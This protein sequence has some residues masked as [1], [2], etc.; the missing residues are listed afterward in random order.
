[1]GVLIAS[2]IDLALDGLRA[3]AFGAI[4]PAAVFEIVDGD[5]LDVIALGNDSTPRF[6]DERVQAFF[7]ELFGGPAA[8][9][10][11][12]DD[13]R[14]VGIGCHSNLSYAFFCAGAGTQPW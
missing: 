7:G 2:V 3:L 1:M 14:V 11:G 5:V 12:A 10:S 6:E 8:G 13:D 9:D 4:I